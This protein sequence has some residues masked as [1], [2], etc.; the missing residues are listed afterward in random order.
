MKIMNQTKI[1]KIGMTPLIFIFILMMPFSFN[2]CKK[3]GVPDWQLA[4]TFEEGVTG[5]PTAG[6]YTYE[7]LATIEYNYF[8]IDDQQM[9]EVLVNDNRW[10]AAGEFIMYT[11]M[12]VVVRLFDIRGNWDFILVDSDSGDELEFSI[13]FFG[14]NLLSGGYTDSQG[15]SGTWNIVN[16]ILTIS[17][18]D[19]SGYVLTGTVNNM[20]GEWTSD[21]SSG[22]WTSNR[23]D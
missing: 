5:S 23:T 1:F 8:P 21:T 20:S 6:V 10:P 17:Y 4:I 7:E 2:S 18:S 16:G 19:W 9:S 13:S 3:F 22:T 12:N 14:E 11:H 15:F